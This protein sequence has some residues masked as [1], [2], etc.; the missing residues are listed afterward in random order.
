MTRY[1]TLITTLLV[2]EVLAQEPAA[3]EATPP[4]DPNLWLI[5]GAGVGA[6]LLIAILLKLRKPNKP[7]T[8]LPDPPSPA[9]V[10]PK[11][12]IENPISLK[13]NPKSD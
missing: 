13:Q 1:F 4:G 10:H 5:I 11:K 8:P 7:S 3:P 12:K 2:S 6:V 9:P